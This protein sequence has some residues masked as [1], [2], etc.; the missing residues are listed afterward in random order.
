MFEEFAALEEVCRQKL[1]EVEPK[2]QAMWYG[3]VCPARGHQATLRAKVNIVGPTCCYSGELLPADPPVKWPG[4]RVNALV[5][6]RGYYVQRLASGTVSAYGLALEVTH[7][8]YEE[9]SCPF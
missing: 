6:V 1:A 5:L 7:L 9:T 3:C 4:L 2:V 8:S